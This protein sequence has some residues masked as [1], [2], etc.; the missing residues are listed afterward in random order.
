MTLSPPTQ[1]LAHEWSLEQH[2]VL[3]EPGQHPLCT[4]YRTC[5]L[6]H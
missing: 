6:C 3:Q 4:L 2:G 5:Q 1:G